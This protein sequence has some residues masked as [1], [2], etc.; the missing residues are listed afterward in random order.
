MEG[1]SVTST[2]KVDSFSLLDSMPGRGRGNKFVK[3]SF[4]KVAPSVKRIQA[5][6]QL[7]SLS[8]A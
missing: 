4:I 1:D 7:G 8:L 2:E 3:K 5:V 6:I